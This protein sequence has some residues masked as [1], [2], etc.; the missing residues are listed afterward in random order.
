VRYD[1]SDQGRED[2]WHG[3]APHGMRPRKEQNSL[4][5]ECK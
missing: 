3:K 2:R 4:I 1:V 5:S